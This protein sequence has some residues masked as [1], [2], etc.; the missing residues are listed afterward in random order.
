M[1][2]TVGFRIKKIKPLPLSELPIEF[3]E[4]ATLHNLT[5]QQITY[6]Y[7]QWISLNRDWDGL[8]REYPTTVEEAFQRP[9]DRFFDNKKLEL[10][11]RREANIVGNWKYYAEYKPGHRY[12]VAGDVAEGIG[13]DN[14]VAVVIDFDAIVD[15]VKKP[16]V[17]AIYVSNTIPPDLFAYELKSAGTRYGNCLIAVERNNHGHATIAILKGVYFN[18]YKEIRTGTMND[19]ETEKIG[20]LT[21]PSTKPKMLFA[22]RNAVNEELINIP[23]QETLNEM[24]D[25]PPLEVTNG[26]KRDR[27]G[28]HWDRIMALSICWQMKD[29]AAGM[30]IMEEKEEKVFNRFSIVGEF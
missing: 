28:S 30:I 27:S 17:V 6:Y 22:I 13:R 1:K 3:Q 15:G 23:D 7:M 26:S 18:L 21:G 25:F 11:K 5:E 8:H 9:G 19:E 2:S 24:R 16:E 14:A 12:A 29:S 20:W 4:Y 10:M